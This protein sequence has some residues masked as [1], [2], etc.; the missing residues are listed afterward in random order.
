MGV[1][2]SLSHSILIPIQGGGGGGTFRLRQFKQKSTSI[3]K[4]R[5]L[6][7][8]IIIINYLL[9]NYYFLLH[10][11]VSKKNN[12]VFTRELIA[13]LN[14]EIEEEQKKNYAYNNK[15]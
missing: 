14:W 12:K 13:K 6:I 7:F 1:S 15:A 5:L 10:F 4:P 3:T 8:T 11:I 9:F 2:I